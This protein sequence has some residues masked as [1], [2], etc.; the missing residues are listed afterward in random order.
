ML[1]D[2][3]T[4]KATNGYLAGS[5]N[6]LSKFH[7]NLGLQNILCLS[8]LVLEEKSKRPPKHFGLS[9]GNYEYSLLFLNVLGTNILPEGH[10]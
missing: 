3:R 9:S 10:V 4:L 5:M 6:L 2:Q 7:C 1:K 8:C